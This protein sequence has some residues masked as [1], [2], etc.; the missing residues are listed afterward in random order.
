MLLVLVREFE[1]RRRE[2]LHLFAK[3]KKD[4]LLRAP[5]VGR[6]N[7]TRV[8]EGRNSSNLLAIKMQRTNRSGR[9]GEEPAM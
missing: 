4:Q 7:S 5:S 1:S 9:G 8:D 6:H 3:I 2:I